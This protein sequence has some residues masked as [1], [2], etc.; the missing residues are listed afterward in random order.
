MVEI[1]LKTCK[2]YKELGSTVKWVI[3]NNPTAFTRKGDAKTLKIGAK[4]LMGYKEK[5]KNNITQYGVKATWL[6]GS[7]EEKK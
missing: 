5:D 4:L 1:S 7:K 2:Y 3:D 6:Y